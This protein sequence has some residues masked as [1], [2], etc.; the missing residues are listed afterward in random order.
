MDKNPRRVLSERI[1][2]SFG[3]PE[4]DAGERRGRPIKEDA[5][6]LTRGR[7]RRNRM[8]IVKMPKSDAMS[9]GERTPFFCFLHKL[10][11]YNVDIR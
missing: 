5:G 6:E 1:F 8:Y 11:S 10:F 9:R 2:V 3:F 7:V 4:G